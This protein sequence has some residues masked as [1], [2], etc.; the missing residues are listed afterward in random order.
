MRI[1][2]VDDEIVSR[3]K[4]DTLMRSF[5]ECRTAENGRQAIALLE[6]AVSDGQAFDLVTLDIN[7]PD[8]QGP[9]VLQHIRALETNR[10]IPENKR[11]CVVMVT[12]QSDKANVLSCIG[13]GCNDYI[14][15]PFN[16]Q[17]IRAKMDKLGLLG[18]SADPA[19]ASR[20][21]DMTA[22]RMISD[23]HKALRSGDFSL[24][25]LPSI[26]V[27]FRE[28]V[29]NNG[30]MGQMADLLKQDMSIASKLI[31]IANSALYR[32][33][34]QVRTIEQAIGRLG[35]A[36]T[37]QMVSA[38]T[39]QRLYATESS[40]FRGILINLWRHSL[41]CAFAAEIMCCS[42]CRTLAVDAFTAGLF[43]DIGS[44]ALIQIV[45][46]MEKRGRFEQE[47]KDEALH[48]TV[49][50][51]HTVFGA[52]LLEK[53]NF[54]IDYQH[55][56]RDHE[57]LEHI[58]TITDQLHVI[59]IANQ[60]AKASGFATFKEPAIEGLAETQSA[61]TLKL[62]A[63]SLTALQ[64]KVKERMAQSDELAA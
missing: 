54:G 64:Q 12:S 48:A 22:E 16:I 18:A 52:K 51:N 63:H 38:I 30:D 36:A 4:M 58:E 26:S 53:W 17:I 24:P 5:G 7:M 3:T 35:L 37:E 23:I 60:L 43:H 32:G 50:A 62:D 46:E 59:H 47:I 6:E 55:I 2:I 34:G 33:F 21:S 44:M 28:L 29:R 39:N 1:L 31:G 27:K 56:A 61:K 8:M 19:P 10:H 13:A 15:K 40:K 9:E 57:N 49:Y 25:V 41:A 42:L 14:T 20:A 45:A 11:S